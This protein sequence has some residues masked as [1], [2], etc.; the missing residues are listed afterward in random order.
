M[1]PAFLVPETK[2]RESGVSSSFDLLAPRPQAIFL[3]LGITHIL[4]QQ[5]LDVSISGSADGEHWD[6]RPLLSFSQ[7]FYCGT[8]QMLLDLDTRPDIRFLRAQWRVNRWGRRDLQPL[9]GFYLH[10]ED[11]SVRVSAPQV[12]ART[13]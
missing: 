4:E 11:A 3:T 5:S 7:K 2:V 8:Y 9:F 1:L 6:S 13:A 12:M 10:A